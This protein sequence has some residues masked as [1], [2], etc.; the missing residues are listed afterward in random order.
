MEEP[1]GGATDQPRSV[2]SVNNERWRS[3]TRAASLFSKAASVC[4]VFYVLMCFIVSSVSSGNES[5][6]ESRVYTKHGTVIVQ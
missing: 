2:C 5:Q 1:L 4:S 6:S 3:Q